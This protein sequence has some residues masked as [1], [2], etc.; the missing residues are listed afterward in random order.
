MP[1]EIGQEVKKIDQMDVYVYQDG[2]ETESLSY[3]FNNILQMFRVDLA[4][5]I[6]V[7]TEIVRI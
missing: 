1:S 3:K 2:I 5:E 6:K 4:V 7:Q